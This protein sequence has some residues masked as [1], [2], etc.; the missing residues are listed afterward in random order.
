MMLWQQIEVKVANRKTIPQPCKGSEIT[1]QTYSG[2]SDLELSLTHRMLLLHWRQR[3]RQA[4]LKSM[5]HM[6]RPSLLG[7][8]CVSVLCCILVAGLAPFQ[9]PRNA[10]T[11]LGNENGVRF[12]NYGTIWSS[13]TLE[14]AVAQDE[15]SCSLEIWLQPERTS[16]SHPLLSFYTPE[17]PLQFW[18]Q[19]FRANLGINR[20]LPGDQHRVV[21]IGIE[22]VF[23]QTKPVFITMA[24]GTQKT[25]I[26]VNGSLA[27]SFPQFRFGENCKGQLVLG[28]SPVRNERWSGLLLGLAI[29]RRELTP[30]QV[31]QHFETWTIHGRPELSAS[32]DAMAIYLF[33]ERAGDIVHNAV[34]P[35]IDL[36]IPKSY[37]LLHQ[38]LLEPFWK[39]FKPRRAYG[40][41]I[42][43]NIAGFIPLGFFFCAYW[44]SV[45]PI[46]HAAL[47]TVVLGFIVSLTIEILQS[48]I[49]TRG[50]GT[51]DL[52]TNSFGTFLG[53]KLYASKTGRAL[54]PK[55][56]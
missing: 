15:P 52:I 45:R 34:R 40:S 13:G 6:N 50:S 49:P 39:E 8:I 44:S 41:D 29:Y 1:Q 30:A 47:S 3:I 4:I 12:G 10:V 19:Q 5:S 14:G 42:L 27:E 51:T 23:S 33:N 46:R 32:E 11:W 43:I 37:S 31:L 53:V 38:K 2:I 28:T 18:L 56:H 16:G 21:A 35:G 54:L 48:Y 9:R 22:G 55:Q 36:H 26:Y 24:S 20:E 7:L 17:N 25:S